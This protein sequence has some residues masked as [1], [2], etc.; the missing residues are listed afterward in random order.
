MWK[1]FAFSYFPITEIPVLPV[2][3]PCLKKDFELFTFYLSGILVPEN[4]EFLTL[5]TVWNPHF[6]CLRTR[7]KRLWIFYVFPVC[8]LCTKIPRFTCLKSIFE[9]TLN[10]SG[11]PV[12]N[13]CPKILWF[14]HIFH[15][16]KTRLKR[17]WTFTFY[18][19]GIPVR[20]YFD[21]FTLSTIWNPRFG[22]LRRPWILYFLPIEL[23]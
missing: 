12:W 16:L 2:W 1:Y 4:F 20:T 19:T 14:F 23:G 13:P 15:Y 18:L 5:S 9:K 10:F 17:L 11:F 22:C 7:L 8:N 21:F 3:N 6:T